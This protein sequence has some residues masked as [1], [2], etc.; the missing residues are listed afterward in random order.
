ML[1]DWTTWGVSVGSNLRNTPFRC[2]WASLLGTRGGGLNPPPPI[3]RMDGWGAL[4]TRDTGRRTRT[5]W[6]PA[7]GERGAGGKTRPT[8]SGDARWAG[9]DDAAL[10]ANDTVRGLRR[11][12]QVGDARTA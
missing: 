2:L 12:A 7:R 1:A 3:P 11:E 6:S 10:E 4:F 5:R 9:C 8:P